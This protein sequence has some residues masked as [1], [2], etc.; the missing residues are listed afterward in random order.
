MILHVP[1]GSSNRGLAE[2]VTG[3]DISD[4]V[5]NQNGDRTLIYYPCDNDEDFDGWGG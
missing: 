1:C 3:E 2:I 5:D 4:F